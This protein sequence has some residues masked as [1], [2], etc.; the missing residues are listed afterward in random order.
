MS[1]KMDAVM[2]AALLTCSRV[3]QKLDLNPLGTGGLL[4]PA[5]RSKT[6]HTPHLTRHWERIQLTKE[7]VV[8][9]WVQ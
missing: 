2:D 1:S 6:A 9:V 3:G 4:Q 8:L 5:T 7:F